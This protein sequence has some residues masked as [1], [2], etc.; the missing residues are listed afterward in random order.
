MGWVKGCYTSRNDSKKAASIKAY[1]VPGVLRRDKVSTLWSS[2]FLS[3][4]CFTNCILYL[5]Y[6]KY[7]VDST[8]SL[9]PLMDISSKVPLNP[10]R[11]LVLSR[12]S[13]HLPPIEVAY[14]HSLCWPSGLFSCPTPIHD[15]VPP[16]PSP[17]P[18]P[19]RS[20]PPFA[21]SDLGLKHP[22]LGP[23]AC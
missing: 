14:F 18:L 19:L 17:S 16:F 15:H 4:M 22:H 10:P 6:S 11:S 1:S 13:S 8:S 21:S 7:L 20:L 23:S 5:G 12:W 9:S 2:F 3:F